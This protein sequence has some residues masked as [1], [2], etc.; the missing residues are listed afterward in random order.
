MA[1]IVIAE[2]MDARAVESLRGDFDVHY[3][4]ALHHD[5]AQIARLLAPARA[6]IVRNRTRVDAGLLAAG[7]RLVAVGRLGVGLDNIDLDACAARAIEVH[8]ATG[9]NVV[10]VA[11]YVIAAALM[12][13]R[14]AFHATGR[15]L[16]GEW[17]REALVGREASGRTL[18]IVGYGAI[19]RAVAV[20]ARALG[21]ELAAFDPLLRADHPAWR[22]AEAR[23]FDDLHGMLAASDV[24]TL[25]VPLNAATRHLVGATAI[26][27]MK[28]GACIINTARGGVLDESALAEAL[29]SGRLGAA[30]LDVFEDE[31]LSASS[32][33]AE[34]PNLY[35]SPHIAGITEE[36]NARTGGLV[37]SRIR[38]ALEP[39][40]DPQ[41]GRCAMHTIA[42][43]M[44]ANENRGRTRRRERDGGTFAMRRS[45]ALA[46]FLSATRDALATRTRV[47]TPSG[48]AAS[49]V[50]DALD[51]SVGVTGPGASQPPPAYR[52]LATA[53]GRARAVPEIAAVAEAF[54][55]LEPELRWSRR[56]GSEAH[57]TVFHDG[58]ANAVIVG[59]TGLE[60]RSDVLIGM[61]LVA[62][63]VRY[64]DH[65]HPPEEVYLVMSDG[66]WYREGDGWHTPGVG[67]ILYNPANVVHAMR[68]GP[69]A[70]L[71][72]WLLP[73][74]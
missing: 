67:G 18:G 16:A 74:G 31:P 6:L 10:A 34:I 52:H 59:P 38:S 36:S 53:L 60:Q 39:V 19:G 63:D 26:A 46:R 47:G 21:M 72:L 35:L 12:M 71:A 40:P 41:E 44:P 17:P 54:A 22:T 65:R 5:A 33:L 50:F 24:V 61:S 7:P 4:P 70:L 51:T 13:L 8:P 58:H 27:A 37:A 55:A 11:E 20:R 1:D 45:F 48:D 30:A 28:R 73:T 42:G 43:P 62:P 15:V 32:P 14:G 3:D 57:G 29:V 2:F 69:Q 49:R 64:V 25:H 66:D 56:A 68:S 9:A 23:R